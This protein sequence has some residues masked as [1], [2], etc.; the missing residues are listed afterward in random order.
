VSLDELLLAAVVLLTR[1]L[2]DPGRVELEP[3]LRHTLPPAAS[4]EVDGRRARRSRSPHVPPGYLRTAGVTVRAERRLD[5]WTRCGV[6][7]RRSASASR[8]AVFLR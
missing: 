2:R 4:S 5:T 1:E 3:E 7:A 8:V 6:A